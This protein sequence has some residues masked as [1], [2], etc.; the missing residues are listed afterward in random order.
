LGT[1]GVL[2]D[3][4]GQ[5]TDA[6]T[7]LNAWHLRTADLT[8]Y[9]G[10]TVSNLN[11]YNFQNGA[12]G[13]WDI[14]VGDVSLVHPDGTSVPIY[15]RS[16]ENLVEF[17]AGA[18][19]SNVSVV[20]EQI[21]A[22][23][24]ISTATFFH[25]DQVGSTDLITASTGWPVASYT[26][27][28]YGLGPMAAGNHYLF[29]G[30]ERD[31]ESNLDYFGA[32][33]YNSSMGRFMSPDYSDSGSAPD[34]IP[35]ADYSN[36]QS[37]NLYAY[38]NNNP[39]NDTDPDGH[40]C[41]DNDATTSTNSNGDLVVNG[42]CNWDGFLPSLSFSQLSQ[43][44]DQAKNAA[45]QG[46]QQI[47]NV[48][49][50]PG[51][52]GC[53]GALAVGGGIVGGSN[54]AAVGLAG[55]P[56]AEITVPSGSAIGG[57]GGAAS[58]VALAMTVCPGGAAFSMAAGGSGGGVGKQGK[59]WKGLKSFRQNIK[60]NGLNGSEKRFYQWDYTHG[61]VEV[62]NGRG[63]H[64]GSADPETGAMTKPPVPGRFLQL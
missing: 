23:D 44:I 56:A 59:F 13:N 40:G 15:S 55:G 37:L 45:I 5:L 4:D 41:L 48:L 52:P 57:A 63:Q 1:S 62:Y 36:P 6:D 46:L 9:A 50:A 29:T 51:G 16:T 34:P 32:R 58:G 25:S 31:Q 3:T 8:T 18:A 61:D 30:K 47:T 17:P 54:G 33:Y 7:T 27:F 49:S 26:Y 60:T 21:G 43:F 38:L 24:G 35:Y 11:L 39:L 2:R 42:N 28:P 53:M 14:F 19:E 64:L 10:N 20:T 22:M 12:P